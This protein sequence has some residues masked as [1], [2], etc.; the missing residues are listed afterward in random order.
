MLAGK[1]VFINQEFI[2]H[3]VSSKKAVQKR[4]LL[5]KGSGTAKKPDSKIFGACD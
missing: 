5:R 3:T 1:D 4:I 2:D